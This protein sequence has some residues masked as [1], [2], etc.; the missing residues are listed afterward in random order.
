MKNVKF[1]KKL[2]LKKEIVANISNLKMKNVVGGN[3]VSLFTLPP[4][5]IFC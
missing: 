3:H 4:T 2:N 1:A 5:I